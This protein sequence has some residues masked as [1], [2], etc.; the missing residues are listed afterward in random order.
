MRS[1]PP[2]ILA[3]DTSAAQ[4]AAALC[5]GARILAA[6]TEPMAQGQAE[7][8]L[9]MIEELLVEADRSWSALDALAVCTG[10]GNF[11][12]VRIAV[13]AAR[14]LAL[15]LGRPAIGVT[16]FQALAAERAGLVLVTLDARRGSVFAQDFED[17]RPLGPAVM[18]EIAALDARPP[19]T[20]C[21]GFAAAEVAGR[22]GIASGPEADTA[23]PAALARA[24]LGRLDRPQPRPAPLY[25]R[26]PDAAPSSE[27]LPI[28]LDDA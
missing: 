24:A 6:R 13:A 16:R 15:A 7:R 20:L 21:V 11:T 19:G 9:P 8:L 2:L 18:T 12:G 25:L 3:F 4:C 14:G 1:D 10:P 27:P 17:G 5:L 22:L 23:D 26:A 28:L